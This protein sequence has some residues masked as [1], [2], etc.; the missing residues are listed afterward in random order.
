ML[1]AKM[2]VAKKEPEGCAALRTALREAGRI[3][4][5][6]DTEDDPDTYDVCGPEPL[7]E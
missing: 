1:K 3:I 5:R 2:N 4:V 6:N 7:I